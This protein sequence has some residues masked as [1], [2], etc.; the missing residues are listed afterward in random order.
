MPGMKIRPQLVVERDAAGKNSPTSPKTKIRPKRHVDG[1]ARDCE[2]S[3]LVGRSQQA[4]MIVKAINA[5][6]VCIY[7]LTPNT[8]RLTARM[9]ES[10]VAAGFDLTL[11]EGK[12]NHVEV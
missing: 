8:P 2:E 9:T 10:R 3:R 12:N 6:K 7:D 1:G 4:K 11:Q 5:H